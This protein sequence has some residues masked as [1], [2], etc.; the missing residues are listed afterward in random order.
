MTG[1]DRRYDAARST[2]TAVNS[3]ALTHGGAQIVDGEDCRVQC[4][5][6]C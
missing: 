2:K 6:W 4:R 5:Q 3:R 1:T